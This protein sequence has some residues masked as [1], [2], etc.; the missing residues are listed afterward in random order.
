MLAEDRARRSLGPAMAWAKRVGI[1]ELHVLAGEG[2]GLL[3]RR[4]AQFRDP[5]RVWSVR[6]HGLSPAEPDPV[7]VEPGALEGL[8]PF[9]DLIRASGAEPVMEAGI[10]RAEV[11]GLEVGRVVMGDDR[12]ELE[13]GVGHHDREGHKA[14]HADEPTGELLEAVVEE[15]SRRRR[16][17]VPSHPANLLSQ[18]RWLRA[19]VIR[20]PELVGAEKL[21]PAWSP[22]QAAA[23]GGERSP[24][25]AIG[26]DGS[27]EPV[28][29]VFSTGV[30]MDL[31]PTAA[32]IRLALARGRSMLRLLLVMPEGDDLP[33]TR[34]LASA[35]HSPAHVVTVER[36]WKAIGD[37]TPHR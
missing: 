16:A 23:I 18:E 21:E 20:R 4:A 5:A 9:G 15:V 2:S 29:A 6:R 12:W 25:A 34:N 13:V 14:L 26:I 35:L 7:P 19:L 32:D 37:G 1:E 22:D 8:G 28:V 30:D 27:G 17:R 24:A 10:L 31:V 36:D 33:I 11:L 3:A